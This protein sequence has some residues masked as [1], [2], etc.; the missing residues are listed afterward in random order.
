MCSLLWATGKRFINRSPSCRIPTPILPCPPGM[1]GYSG[2]DRLCLRAEGVTHTNEVP[3]SGDPPCWEII[4]FLGFFSSGSTL[5]TFYFSFAKKRLI[6]IEGGEVRSREVNINP[7]VLPST[8]YTGKAFAQGGEWSDRL[9]SA[10][11]FH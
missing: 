5:G 11:F 8:P 6:L 3:I 4:F 10:R 2:P 1:A 7:N 9:F